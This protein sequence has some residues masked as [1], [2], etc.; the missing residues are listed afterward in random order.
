M[1][2]SILIADTATYSGTPESLCDLATFNFI[3]G[4]NATG[5][6]T[7]SR[8][9]ANEDSFPSCVVSWKGGTRLQPM[10]YNRDFIETNFNQ[11]NE[12]KGVFTLGEKNV[13][14]INKIAAAKI[15]LDSITK[16]IETLTRT[17]QG[18]DGTG[19][20]KGELAA[21]EAEIRNKC[22]AQKQKHDAKL[23]GAFEG[24]RNSA[25]KFKAKV[26]QEWAAN[27]ATVETLT[28]LEKKAESVFGQ[29]PTTEKLT[30][31]LEADAMLAHEGNPILKK[32]V[33]GKEDVDIAAMI[34]KLGN[35][36]WVREGRGFYDVNDGVCPFC[37]QA[38]AEAF[39]QS[40]NEYFDEAFEADSKAI[41]D[42]VTNYR[43]DSSRL[44]Q[45]LSSIIIDP[46]KFID[47]EKLRMEKDLL[48]STVTVNIQ[49][50]TAKKKEP[51]QVAELQ[52]LGNV[53][54]TIKGLIDASNSLVVKHNT[55]V[56]NLSRERRDLTAQVWKYL[57]EVELKVDLDSYK[58]K[59]DA[60]NKAVDGVTEQIALATKEKNKTAAG[61]RE[62]EKLTTSI[63]PTIDGINALLSSF[64]FQSFL[65]A[66]ADNGKCYKLVRADG[67]DAKATLSEGEK[68]FVTFLYFYHL[69][70]GSDSDSGMTTDR[71]VVIDDPVSSLDS[72]ILFIVSSLIKGL[73]EEVRDGK[74]H[75]KQ[76]FVL[77]H[78]VYFHKEVTFNP[79]RRGKTM[80]EETFWVV[81]KSGLVSKI[82]KHD[83]NP[84]RT[85]YDLLWGE[86][87]K[88][89]HSNLT[90]QNTL[91][92]ILE[93]YFKILGGV[94]PDAICTL[95]DGKEKLICKSLFS[96]VNEGSHYAHD[97][98][99]I[100]VDDAVVDAYLQVFKAIFEKS[101]HLAHYEMMMAST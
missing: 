44:Q 94:D 27:S 93:N 6:T 13:E 56:A 23:Q 96:W 48:D 84:I 33:I 60:L 46:S 92:R 26:F 68:N 8:V 45:Q 14:T 38:T 18:E 86:V 100:S 5:K 12:L 98:L 85:S 89:D 82:E 29:T 91:R 97:D 70:K 61:I 78:N 73:F 7:V 90:I 2:E 34:K 67:A 87:R 58:T 69:L 55:M 88:P 11:S 83:C 43:T 25:E 51:S 49:K 62:L 40:L 72:D 57:L 16:K 30:P 15:E 32:R 76:V 3:F 19:G 81:R 59:R 75:I 53:L 64:G 4:G 50:L 10:V 20:K 28:E 36:D 24:F 77:T 47:I 42:L 99:Y 21:L 63:Q 71:V 37:Q 80:T 95:F 17:L 52:S 79:K 31:G 74:G 66:K 39:A 101:G 22:W 35:S 9:I 65:I 1:I 54:S 41:D